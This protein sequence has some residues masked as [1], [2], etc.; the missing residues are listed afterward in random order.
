MAPKKKQP[1]QK[2]VVMRAPPSSAGCGICRSSLTASL[3]GVGHMIANSEAI[4]VNAVPAS[5]T[6]ANYLPVVPS[7]LPWL[8]GIAKG[9]QRFRWHHV[10]VTFLSYGGKEATGMVGMTYFVDN[11]DKQP[12]SIAALAVQQNASIGS[13]AVVAPAATARNLVAPL[14]Q[15]IGV[16]LPC[17][18]LRGSD[19]Q[20]A[21]DYVGR[22]AWL[23]MSSEV[24]DARTPLSV[25]Y[26]LEGLNG[27]VA[28]P[29]VL[30]VSY[31]VELLDS[32]SPE[33]NI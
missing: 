5:G 3:E 25:C 9:Y 13:Y 4:A 24:R 8:A 6:V 22:D 14:G 11:R 31:C 21:Y 12:T 1:K 28:N 30:M 17:K 27:A 20:R 29:G 26:V 16:S 15:S 32:I 23:A 33:L 10:K 7:F 19:L 2:Q 18:T